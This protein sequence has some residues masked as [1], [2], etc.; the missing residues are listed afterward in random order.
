M[1][2]G[3]DQGWSRLTESYQR[4]EARSRRYYESFWGQFRDVEVSNAS[5]QPPDR[6]E[7]TL[8]YRYKSGRV[9]VE[10]RAFRFVNDDGQLK[11]SESYVITRG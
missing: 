7:A 6:A 8:T 3:T 9:D 1:P 2:E 11:I 10:R 5:G 4:G